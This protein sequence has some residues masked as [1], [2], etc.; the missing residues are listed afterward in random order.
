MDGTLLY[1]GWAVPPRF[2][3]FGVPWTDG[4]TS[5]VVL[6]RHLSGEERDNTYPPEE[7]KTGDRHFTLSQTKSEECPGGCLCC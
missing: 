2:V 1:C 4:D 3:S 5:R 7:G 6:L